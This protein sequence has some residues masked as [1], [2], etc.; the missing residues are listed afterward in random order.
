MKNSEN[1]LTFEQSLAELEKI[2]G[3]LEE[4]DVPLDEAIALFEKGVNLSKDCA[5]KLKKAKQ[6]IEKLT[7]TGSDDND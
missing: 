5:E 3:R 4:N 1:D 6:K 2:S 7:A